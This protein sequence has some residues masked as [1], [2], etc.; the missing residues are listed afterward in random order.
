MKIMNKGF[1]VALLM[2]ATF[3]ALSVNTSANEYVFTDINKE[4]PT[5]TATAVYT[6]SGRGILAG[7]SISEDGIAFFGTG[8]ILTRAEMACI[9]VRLLGS[10][11]EPCDSP[12][13]DINGH[14]A[15]DKINRAY[16]AGIMFGT[17]ADAFSPNETLTGLEAI[18][19]LLRVAG[20]ADGLVGPSWALNTLRTADRRGVKVEDYKP[21]DYITRGDVARLIIDLGL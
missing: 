10:D 18:V 5:A 16:E 20:V 15:E 3:L 19:T 1:F 11:L 17:S 13:N 4:T 14:W 9:A 7:K 8:D 21:F 12:F 2:M 6:L